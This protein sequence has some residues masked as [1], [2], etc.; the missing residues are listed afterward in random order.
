[1]SAY[2]LIYSEIIADREASNYGYEV[3]RSKN[4]KDFHDACRYSKMITTK[5][6]I[7]MRPIIEIVEG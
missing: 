4:F 6:N 2:K 3:E 1:M 5:T 7:R